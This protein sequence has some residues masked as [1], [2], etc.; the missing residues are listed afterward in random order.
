MDLVARTDYALILMDMQLP[1]LDGLAATQR[2]RATGQQM[3]IVAMTANAFARTGSVAWLP[4]WTT[5]SAS[6]CLAE[7]LFATI[8]KW[9]SRQ[10]RAR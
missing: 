9:L 7:D 1:Q 6:P 10:R 3:P 8:L 5:M 4:G 2:I